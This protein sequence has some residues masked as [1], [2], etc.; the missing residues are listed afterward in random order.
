ML[1]PTSSRVFQFEFRLDNPLY[2][3]IQY[4]T[5]WILKSDLRWPFHDI[6]T[7]K[8]GQGGSINQWIWT[9]AVQ[10]F[11]KQYSRNCKS[12]Y[13]RTHRLASSP[14]ECVYKFVSLYVLLTFRSATIRRPGFNKKNDNGRVGGYILQLCVHSCQ[15]KSI[16]LK[17][18]KSQNGSDV[19]YSCNH[20]SSRFTFPIFAHSCRFSVLHS[21]QSITPRIY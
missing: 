12:M 9:S 21:L 19:R 15:Q 16:D 4:L 6:T 1:R 20:N 5:R 10:L 14:G 17:F 3:Q 8:V 18:S 11:P 13:T 2:T 7:M